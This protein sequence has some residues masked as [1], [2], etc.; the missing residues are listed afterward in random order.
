M[1]KGRCVTETVSEGYVWN[2]EEGNMEGVKGAIKAEDCNWKGRPGVCDR[3]R[4]AR[5]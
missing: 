3:D 4:T 2:V 5:A 1:L